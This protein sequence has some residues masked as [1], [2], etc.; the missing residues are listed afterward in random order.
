MVAVPARSYLFAPADREDL[1]QKVLQAG[2]DAVV[3]DLEDAVPMAKKQH[4]RELVRELLSR[5]GREP[6]ESIWVRVNS[7]RGEIWKDDIG[8][9]RHD[10]GGIEGIRIPKVESAN[11]LDPLTEMLSETEQR[12]G[13]EQE[14]VRLIC[15]LESARGV[16]AAEE[17]ARHP[18]VDRLAFGAADFLRD[19][20]ADPD[21]ES[22]ATLW[23]KSSMVVAS[24]AGRA[25]APIAPVFTRLEDEEG[26]RASTIECRNLGFFGR[27]CIHPRQL[28]IVNEVFTPSPE[29][30][31]QA[32]QVVEAF[33]GAARSGSGA[34][35]AADGQFIDL[36]VVQRAQDLLDLADSLA[37]APLIVL[38]GG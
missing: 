14:S 10:I 4:A 27:S 25:G 29:K 30:I 36:A 38:E 18:R 2:A 11:E 24:R 21:S 34:I 22:T 13:L 3:L 37:L 17:I 33:S 9:L 12:A 20:G 7:L 8:A 16:L 32:R 6:G 23:A 19:I 26:L 15:T 5:D 35:V 28:P 31:L 1:L